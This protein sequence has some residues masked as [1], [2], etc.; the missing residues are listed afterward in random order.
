MGD[1]GHIIR[2]LGKWLLYISVFFTGLL[3][4]ILTVLFF[5]PRALSTER[6]R[7]FLEGKATEAIHRNIHIEKMTWRWSE[8]IVMRGIDMKDDPSFSSQSLLSIGEI[9]L[10]MHVKELLKGRIALFFQC[11]DL[12]AHIIRDKEGATNLQRLVSELG[13][14]RSTKKSS[15]DKPFILP[16]D[17]QGTVAF[18]T[19]SLYVEDQSQGKVIEAKNSSFT[20]TVP[21][22]LTKPIDVELMAELSVDGQDLPPVHFATS[23]RDIFNAEG[24]MNIQNAVITSKGSLLGINMAV[25]GSLREEGVESKINIDAG[26]LME[27]CKALLPPDIAATDIG[28]DF[29]LLCHAIG[30]PSHQLSFETS[31]TG[32]GLSGSGGLLKE[33]TL[34]PVDFTL[35]TQGSFHQNEGRV[36]IDELTLCMPELYVKIGGNTLHIEDMNLLLSYLRASLKHCALSEA[37]LQGSLRINQM[38]IEGPNNLMIEKLQ[39]P[40]VAIKAAFHGKE[41]L[42]V[43]LDELSLGASSVLLEHPELGAFKTGVEATTRIEQ[44]KISNEN[45]IDI[46][47]IETSVAF[48]KFLEIHMEAGAENLAITHMDTKGSIIVTV[49]ELIEH[50]PF[51]LKDTITHR[52]RVDGT[53]RVGWNMRGRLP[54]DAEVEKLKSFSTLTSF[55]NGM[56][57][58]EAFEVGISLKDIAVDM[59]LS[60]HDSIKVSGISTDKPVMVVLEG[61][62][63]KRATIEGDIGV[64]SIEQVPSFQGLKKPLKGS[65]YFSILQDSLKEMKIS[66]RIR[67]DQL[68]L[69]QSAHVTLSGIDRVLHRRLDMPLP[70]LLTLLRGEVHGECSIGEG[71][72][73]AALSDG[74]NLKGHLNAGLDVT[75]LSGRNIGARCWVDSSDMDVEIRELLK[76]HKLQLSM[77]FDKRY[78]IIHG[79]GEEDESALSAHLLSEVVLQPATG[80][81]TSP[82]GKEQIA[83]RLVSDM[84]GQLRKRRSLSC[85]SVH[86]NAEPIPLLFNNIMLDVRLDRGLPIMDHF[87]IDVL[88]GT[89]VSSLSLSREGEEFFIRLKG[90]FSGVDASRLF[91]GVIHNIPSEETEI[92]GQLSLITPLS[93]QF[94]TLLAEMELV[95]EITHIGSRTLER[96]LYAMDPYEGNEIIV[97]QR[98][99]LRTGTPRWIKLDMKRGSLLVAGEVAV[100][101]ISIPLPQVDVN[102]AHLPGI[103]K[104]QPSLSFLDRVHQGLNILSSDILEIDDQG[105]VRF[106]V[107]P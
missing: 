17:L 57:F 36:S 21:S 13:E 9:T 71:A 29:E 87:Q 84:E 10:V 70:L 49:P 82:A 94:R 14:S 90:L 79:K 100:S 55:D 98:K 56:E 77:N 86:I 15:V 34:G 32:A 26:S 80:E 69:E 18:R 62:G 66:E 35:H 43:T 61:G 6:F 92:S 105:R 59:P 83:S 24:L 5:L 81:V 3:F 47:G 38:R 2:K 107:L 88:G 39:M 46:T 23:I 106:H 64:R 40:A 7:V 31:L 28:G 48:D 52:A 50:L 11:D 101:G 42:L 4:I 37:S 51:S 45:R 22:L 8:G 103:N 68:Q 67:I 78:E 72:D 102:A 30:D 12:H 27:T 85:A 104:F 33:K 97:K 16:L 73:L 89:L 63:V 99:L 65:I 19:I 44:I 41:E 91:P 53:V 58:L 74:I 95:M 25:N 54:R 20:L 1:K 76:A 60:A 75:L 96:I 93:A